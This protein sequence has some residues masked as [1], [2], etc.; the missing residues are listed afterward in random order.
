MVL[1]FKLLRVRNPNLGCFKGENV[2][3]LG[4]LRV[5]LFLGLGFFKGEGVSG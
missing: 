5:R 4:F 3:G 2:K 1:D